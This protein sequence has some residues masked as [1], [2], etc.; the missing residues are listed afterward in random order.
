MNTKNVCVCMCVCNSSFR[1]HICKSGT[2]PDVLV[3]TVIPATKE[4]ETGGTQVTGK[5][6]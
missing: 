2:T 1:K 4:A 5:P 6:G 3:T